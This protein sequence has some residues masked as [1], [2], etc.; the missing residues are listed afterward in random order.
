MKI[1]LSDSEI[2]PAPETEAV[3]FPKYVGQIVNRANRFSQGTRPKVVGKLTELFKVFPGT[4]VGEWEQ[5]YVAQKPQAIEQATE[6]IFAMV[7]NFKGAIEKI[8]RA[9]IEAW[10]RDLVIVKTF[11]GLRL[12]KAILKKGAELVNDDYRLAE[13]E[14]ESKGIDGYI[15]NMAVSIKPVTYKLQADLKET[16]AGAILYYE[17]LEDGIEVDYSEL[18]K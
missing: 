13:R 11:G 2:G 8:D 1:K 15:G 10:T 9:M 16:L 5:W 17:K 3:K 4:T 18:V 14:E 12:Q 7:G 6:K